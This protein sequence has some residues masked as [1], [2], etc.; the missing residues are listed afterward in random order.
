[1]TAK[2]VVMRRTVLVFACVMLVA[3]V[4]GAQAPDL[5]IKKFQVT[6]KIK[7]GNLKAVDI[8]LSVSNS[9]GTGVP[10]TAVVTGTQNGDQVYGVA[11]V[12]YDPPG[13]EPTAYRFPPYYPQEEGEILWVAVVDDE[14]PD[15]DIATAVTEVFR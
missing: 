14:D 7:L 9:S 1:M 13:R 2:E 11:T 4:A 10:C 6:K 3:G 5:D 8:R 15:D 12:V